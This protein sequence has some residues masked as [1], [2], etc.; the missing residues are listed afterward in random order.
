MRA[1]V[2]V[3]E[4]GLDEL[5]ATA[6]RKARSVRRRMPH[7]AVLSHRSVADLRRNTQSEERQPEP[8]VSRARKRADRRSAPG[9]AVLPRRRR[10]EHGPAGHDAQPGHPDARARVGQDSTAMDFGVSVNPEFLREGTALNDFQKP[11]LTLVGHN[12]AM[13]ATRTT[14]LYPSMDAPLVN[15]THPRRRDGEVHEQLLAR[16]QGVFRERD[17]QSLQAHGRRQPSS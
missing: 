17:R 8:R 12:H 16:A 5:L 9:G 7:E 4:P 2:P 13:D 15:T 3:V 6:S 11:P 1:T 10:P 14:E